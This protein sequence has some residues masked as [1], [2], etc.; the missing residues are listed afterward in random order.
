M[1]FKEDKDEE[2]Q[3]KNKC[4]YIKSEFTGF[5]LIANNF[6]KQGNNGREIHSKYKV[7][8]NTYFT[9]SFKLI[10]KLIKRQIGSVLL[11][12]RT[13]NCLF[14]FPE[15]HGTLRARLFFYKLVDLIFFPLKHNI[16]L[17]GQNLFHLRANLSI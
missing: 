7:R 11:N 5:N 4:L 17:L 3:R 14:H 2:R 6:E 9:N 16:W 1:T 13:N 10:N 12:C 15:M 8:E